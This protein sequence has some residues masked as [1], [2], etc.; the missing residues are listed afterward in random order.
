MIAALDLG[1][2]RVKW[3]L[4]PGDLPIEGR[5]L[6]EGAVVP[7]VPG[8]PVVLTRA[9]S[10]SMMEG[11]A[12]KNAVVETLVMAVLYRAGGRPPTGGRRCRAAP[13]ALGAFVSE[14]G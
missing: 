2:T 6:S 11:R 5:F 14:G 8:V 7:G 10:R 1:N 12:P 3:G 13:S 9:R 4:H